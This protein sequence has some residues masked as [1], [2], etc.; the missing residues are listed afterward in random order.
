MVFLWQGILLVI[1][2]LSNW[3]D[4]VYAMHPG[5]LPYKI[6]LA[7]PVLGVVGIYSLLLLPRV[8]L[9]KDSLLSIDIQYKEQDHGMVDSFHT[10]EES[11]VKKDFKKRVMELMKEL[12]TLKDFRKGAAK[13]LH[14]LHL[15]IEGK[16]LERGFISFVVITSFLTFLMY[17]MQGENDVSENHLPHWMGFQYIM[18]NLFATA[19]G[20]ALDTGGHTHGWGIKNVFYGEDVDQT[21]IRWFTNKV[22]TDFVMLLVLFDIKLFKM[23]I[24]GLVK[25]LSKQKYLQLIFK[26]ARGIFMQTYD[27]SDTWETLKKIAAPFAWLFTTAFGFHLIK[28]ALKLVGDRTADDWG[29]MSG[30][31]GMLSMMYP[32]YLF[33]NLTFKQMK[34]IP[35]ERIN[36]NDDLPR[37]IA[38]YVRN[39]AATTVVYVTHT[40]LVA[41][42]CYAFLGFGDALGYITSIAE[43]LMV[44]PGYYGILLTLQL[45]YQIY[46]GMSTKFNNEVTDAEYGSNVN[47][48]KVTYGLTWGALL[49]IIMSLSSWN[50]ELKSLMHLGESEHLSYME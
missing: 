46:R 42:M 48:S 17:F 12:F 36:I 22:P 6:E 41:Y 44:I 35:V 29:D 23:F 2:A 10:V 34:R 27:P 5:I 4:L 3:K 37:R 50:N 30:I 15:Y 24:V 18:H 38:K 16:E 47:L 14:D 45:V 7:N 33:P 8:L 49:V 20:A 26:L 9:S 1:P 19:K 25:K 28:E 40:F 31:A 13:F 21:W 43:T 39:N 11:E 32:V